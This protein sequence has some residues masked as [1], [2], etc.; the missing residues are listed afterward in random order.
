MALKQHKLLSQ[1]DTDAGKGIHVQLSLPD[2]ADET[3]RLAFVQT[4]K[5]RGAFA[6]QLS[7]G[8]TWQ[9]NGVGGWKEIGGGGGLQGGAFPEVAIRVTQTLPT[10]ADSGGVVENLVGL[11]TDHITA[12]AGL[13]AISVWVMTVYANGQLR[14]EQYTGL[15]RFSAGA[16]DPGTRLVAFPAQLN[17]LGEGT[18]DPS[19]EVDLD[20]LVGATGIVRMAF[21]DGLGGQG[22][23]A[24]IVVAAVSPYYES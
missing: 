13:L 10:I 6:W 21:D 12:N 11:T 23:A 9:A 1:N 14:Q 20:S 3:A 18:A 16:G 4:T 8:T 2:F 24:T 7:D 19:I 5:D 22:S 17:L 15:F